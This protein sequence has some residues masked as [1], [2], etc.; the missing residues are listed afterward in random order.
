MNFDPGGSGRTIPLQGILPLE[1]R[2]QTGDR[3]V[4]LLKHPPEKLRDFSDSVDA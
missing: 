1:K 2:R 4:S 3:E